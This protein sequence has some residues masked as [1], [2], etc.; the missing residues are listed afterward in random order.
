MKKKLKQCI[1]RWRDVPDDLL[2][3]MCGALSPG[4][5]IVT[6]LA[7]CTLFGACSLYLTVSSIYH[8]GWKDAQRQSGDSTSGGMKIEHIRQLD[9]ASGQLSRKALYDSI[10]KQIN[11]QTNGNKQFSGRGE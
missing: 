7:M 1:A 5:R 10:H 4:K 9:L 2:R 3:Q 8:I 6:I 11:R